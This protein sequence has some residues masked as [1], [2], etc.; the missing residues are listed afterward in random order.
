MPK[1]IVVISDR[2]KHDAGYR[3]NRF[4]WWLAAKAGGYGELCLYWFLR[5]YFGD[6]SVR[7]IR[8]SEL[9][10]RS[11]P[12]QTDFLMVGVPTL[13]NKEHLQGVRYKKLVLYDSS[14]HDGI[15]FLYS[16]ESFLVSQ[17]DLCLKHYRDSRWTLPMRIGL[18]P[19]KRPPMN[20]RL[21]WKLRQQRRCKPIGSTERPYDVGFVARP[22]GDIESNLRLR[23]W[24][25]IVQQ[26]PDLRRWGGLVGD[27]KWRDTFAESDVP[28]GCWMGQ[29]KVHF[30]QYFDGLQRSKVALAPP[31]YAPWTFRHYE[32]IYAGCMVVTTDL[33][34]YEFLVPLPEES[35]VQLDHDE[36]IVDG[37]RRAV[38]LAEVEPDR[39]IFARRKLDRWLDLGRYRKSCTDTLDRFMAGLAD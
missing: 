29:K 35:L 11:N 39:I 26:S 15:N 10:G 2:S 32:A 16:D 4:F 31:G 14:D 36:S 22:T 37:V 33:R 30:S 18:L 21:Y 25:E 1:F 17:T 7:L 38:K 23:W 3:K 13:L 20:N 6:G 5:E 28:E 24:V 12:M 8:P 19:I 9:L 27:Q 34:H